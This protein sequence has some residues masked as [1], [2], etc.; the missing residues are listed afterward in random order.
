MWMDSSLNIHKKH[1][2]RKVPKRSCWEQSAF[3][4]SSHV[5]YAIVFLFVSSFLCLWF[6]A[7]SQ[8][9]K[10]SNVSIIEKE[11]VWGTP[12]EVETLFIC[13]HWFVL[14]FASKLAFIMSVI[15][16]IYLFFS[17]YV[18]VNFHVDFYQRNLP[19]SIDF[20]EKLLKNPLKLCFFYL[21][22]HSFSNLN[23]FTNIQFLPIFFSLRTLFNICSNWEKII[24]TDCK[25][26]MQHR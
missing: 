6:L 12:Q 3:Y 11:S 15:T 20:I 9:A 24:F 21:I 1:N 23:L 16:F 4:I 2:K 18:Y 8:S 25:Q 22:I 26:F 14:M 5:S 7:T 13:C 19:V 17:V 10:Y